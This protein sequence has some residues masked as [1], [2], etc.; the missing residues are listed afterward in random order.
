LNFIKFRKCKSKSS[1][2]GDDKLDRDFGIVI[3]SS[4][5]DDETDRDLLNFGLDV[6]LG[7]FGVHTDFFLND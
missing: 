7:N 4:E 6:S 1:S 2:S 5:E 3:K